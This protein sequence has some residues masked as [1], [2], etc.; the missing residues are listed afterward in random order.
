MSEADRVMDE[1]VFGTYKG[2]FVN[3]DK[4]EG[5]GYYGSSLVLQSD[6]ALRN[7]FQLDTGYDIADYEF[8]EQQA[9]GTKK[10][11]Q[12]QEA[13]SSLYYI[14]IDNV[15]AYELGDNY[16]I[17]IKKKSDDATE[18]MVECGMFVY[19]RYVYQ[20][21]DNEALKNLMKAMYHYNNA[22]IEYFYF[23]S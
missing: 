17:Y 3:S 6:T 21:S 23:F 14:D 2:K 7:Y 18:M 11:I 1:V 13:E 5:I 4:I 12:P 22:A 16:N 20:Y 15:K 10:I 9:D 8:Y 19:A